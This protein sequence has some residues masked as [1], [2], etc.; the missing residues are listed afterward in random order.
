MIEKTIIYSLENILPTAKIL[1]DEIEQG[2]IVLLSGNPGVGKSTLIYNLIKHIESQQYLTQSPTFTKIHEY[3][4]VI[5]MDWYYG[6]NICLY[7]DY[8]NSEKFIFIEWG[9]GLKDEI[10]WN[11][12]W[13]L[14]TLDENRRQ[15]TIYK[16]IK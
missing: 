13:H 6:Q 3:P 14:D 10:R 7:E 12:H 9:V 15:I 2:D 16:N 8:L 4:Q 5:H 11:Y 1:L